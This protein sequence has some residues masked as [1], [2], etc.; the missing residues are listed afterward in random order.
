MSN[1]YSDQYCELIYKYLVGHA[2][3]ESWLLLYGIYCHA[4]DDIIDGDETSDEHKLKTFETGMLLYSHIF[5]QRN[6]AMLYP[7]VKMAHTAYE[8]SVRL[9]KSKDPTDQLIADP[10]RQYGNEIIL[11]VIE[12]VSGKA[13][14]DAASKE[15]RPLSYKTHHTLEGL[16]V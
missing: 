16:P 4:I 1:N 3:A 14:R 7:L 5:Y 13:A 2:D 9:E 11:A 12:L 6:I 15:L 8:D 10:L